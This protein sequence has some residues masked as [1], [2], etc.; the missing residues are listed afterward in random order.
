MNRVLRGQMTG[1]ITSYSIHYTKLYDHFS[2]IVKPIADGFFFSP[3]HLTAQDAVHPSLVKNLKNII[4]ES[5]THLPHRELF[6]KLE[7]CQFFA[8]LAR[9]NPAL[10]STAE[11]LST[12][13]TTNMKLAIEYLTDHYSEKITIRTM[14]E[15]M[16]MSEQHFSRLFKTYT[17]KT[18]VEY[19]TLYRLECANKLLLKSNLPITQ[20]PELTGFCNPNYF[21]RVYKNYYGHSPSQSRK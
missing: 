9:Y 13:H 19:L 16:N 21:S 11:T 1:V 14:T 3:C 15:L 5:A 6:I 2:A 4:R 18:F 12:S 10:F 17:G 8:S 7:L 20:I